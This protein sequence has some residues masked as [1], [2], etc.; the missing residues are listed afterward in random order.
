LDSNERER[1]TTQPKKSVKLHQFFFGKIA[2][3][4]LQLELENWVVGL[5]FYI[6]PTVVAKCSRRLTEIVFACGSSLG[7]RAPSF[8]S[9]CDT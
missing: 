1:T 8:C 9:V 7:A 3:E 2:R 6:G 5:M 4:K